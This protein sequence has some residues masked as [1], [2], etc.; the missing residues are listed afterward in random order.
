[1]VEVKFAGVKIKYILDPIS[2]TKN[3]NYTVN[4][5]I[6]TGGGNDIG[7]LSLDGMVLSFNSVV[8]KK[9]TS[10]LSAYRKLSKNYTKKA[11][12]LV[13]SKDLNVDGKYYL[14]GYNEEKKVNGSYN[15]SW[16]FTEYVKPNV[17]KKSFKRVGKSATKKSSGKTSA[18]KTKP[19][20]TS[21]YIT[22]LLSDCGTLKYGMT[23]KKC[24]KYL[25]K[26][27]QKKGYYKGY[28]IDGDYLQ[29]T[30]AAVNQMQKAYKIKVSK[31]NKGQWDT[32]TRN[33]WRKKYNII[34]KQKAKAKARNIVNN[35]LKDI[36]KKKKKW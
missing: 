36:S 20:K 14:T 33:Y 31:D 21:K 24:V 10:V 25:Q 18:K 11:G 35:A 7:F 13:G 17:V 23:N 19:K 30:K 34:S 22:I 15:I 29:Y 2:K 5:F 12:V 9:D 8:A 1:M 32:V 4:T 26:F 27:L 16:E 28:K 6:G 3:R